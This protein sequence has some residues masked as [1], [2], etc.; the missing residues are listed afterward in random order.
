MLSLSVIAW[1]AREIQLVYYLERKLRDLLLP[2]KILPHIYVGAK[3][4][5]FYQSIFPRLPN[6]FYGSCNNVVS[7]QIIMMLYY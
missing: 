5:E 7:S 1:W 6:T 4:L 2:S 3:L